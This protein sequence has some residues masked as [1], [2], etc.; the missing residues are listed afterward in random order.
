MATAVKLN[1]LEN[2]QSRCILY[3]QIE[4]MYLF[5]LSF[6]TLFRKAMVL[7]EMGQVDESLQFFLHCLAVDEDFPCAKRQVE[8][9]RQ[10]GGAVIDWL[11]HKENETKY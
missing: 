1:T 5:F 6:Q 8:K 4:F 3:R 11:M 9:V 10:P 2:T 7:H